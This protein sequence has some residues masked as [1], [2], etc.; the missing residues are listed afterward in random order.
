MQPSAVLPWPGRS[1]LSI[2]IKDT[3]TLLLF[4]EQRDNTSLPAVIQ[5]DDSFIARLMSEIPGVRVGALAQP[6]RR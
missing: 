4:A 3:R 6:V 5:L 2:A 1:G